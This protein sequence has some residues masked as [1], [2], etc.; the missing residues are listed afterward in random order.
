LLV[1]LIEKAY[2]YDCGI[3]GESSFEIEG[4]KFLQFKAKCGKNQYDTN[5][6]FNLNKLA[7]SLPVVVDNRVKNNKEKANFS[8]QLLNICKADAFQEERPSVVTAEMNCNIGKPILFYDFNSSRGNLWIRESEFETLFP[9]L[10]KFYVFQDVTGD[11]VKYLQ[12]QEDGDYILKYYQTDKG[13]IIAKSFK[14]SNIISEIYFK[15]EGL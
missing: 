7:F 15:N 2:K 10:G 14:G 12:S 1:N 5:I 6:T 3:V 9:Y 11:K 13:V 4:E 8:Y